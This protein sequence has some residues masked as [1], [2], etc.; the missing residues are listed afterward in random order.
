M[1]G[2]TCEKITLKLKLSE[3]NVSR[4]RAVY[5]VFVYQLMTAVWT[6]YITSRS[7]RYKATARYRALD[8]D[9]VKNQPSDCHL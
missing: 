4:A 7:G 6:G 9:K 8:K 3:K 2:F 1:H 5:I